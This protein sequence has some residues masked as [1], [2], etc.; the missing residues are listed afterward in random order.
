[1]S[2]SQDEGVDNKPVAEP[3]AEPIDLDT[4][5]E[6][7][8][9]RAVLELVEHQRGQRGVEGVIWVNVVSSKLNNIGVKTVQDFVSTVMTVNSR[10]ARGSHRQLHRATLTEM[11]C[12]SC[13]MA[14]GL[15]TVDDEDA[16]ISS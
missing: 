4:L 14:F 8:A 16:E 11:L 1:M 2:D 15:E 7:G 10:L 6:H 3:V 12:K 9:A 5:F 13:K